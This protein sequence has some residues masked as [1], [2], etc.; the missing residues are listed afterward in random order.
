MP[1][2][3][4]FNLKKII[5]NPFFWTAVGIFVI[6]VA[7]LLIFNGSIIKK[8]TNDFALKVNDK[9]FSYEDVSRAENQLRQQYMMQGMNL[10]DSQIREMALKSLIQQALLMEFLDDENIEVSDAELASHLQEILAMSGVSEEEFFD[11]LES[12]GLDN[13]D[14]I[15]EILIFEIRLDKYFEMLAENVNISDEEIQEAYEEFL[16]QIEEYSQEEEISPEDIPSFEDLKD[17]IKHGLIEERIMPIVLAQLD[18]MEKEATIVNNLEE[19]E[20]DES[21]PNMEMFDFDDLDIDFE[22]LE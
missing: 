8:D 17:Q 22:D 10:S 11:R 12:D 1:K 16:V 21:L 9:E 2:V 20:E 15:D 6:F 19:I 13:R 3:K 4:K 18:D 7:Y 14:E 5:K